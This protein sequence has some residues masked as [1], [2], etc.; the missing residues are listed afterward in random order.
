M[1]PPLLTTTGPPSEGAS[2]GAV[3]GAAAEG[4]AIGA[5]H[6]DA[7]LRY[8]RE[9]GPGS[10][11]ALGK[12]VGIS[13]RSARDHLARLRAEG[14]VEKTGAR[15][16]LT[17]A[18][19]ARTG[20]TATAADM[21]GVLALLPSE[22][23]RAWLRLVRDAVLCRTAHAG[24]G[25]RGWPGFAA[26]GPPGTMKTSLAALAG[27][28][29]GLADHEHVLVVSDRAP[30]D[31]IGRKD[32]RGRWQRAGAIGLPVL[33]LDELDKAAGDRLAIALRLLQG[34]SVI[35]W[36]GETFTMPATVLCTFN[37]GKDPRAVLPPDR[38]RR[39]VMLNTSG[40]ASPDAC[41]AAARTLLRP[42][43]LPVLDAGRL[44]PSAEP[45]ADDVAEL[46]GAELSERML[47]GARALL[48]AEGLA[49]IVPGR[50]VNDSCSEEEAALAIGRDYLVCAE[51]WGG[52][53]ARQ[54]ARWCRDFGLD[55]PG[56]P[57]PADAAEIA[58][59]DTHVDAV[60]LAGRRA[61]ARRSVRAERDA[62]GR[63]DDAEAAYLRG[64][65][66]ELLRQVDRVQTMG[67]LRRLDQTFGRLRALGEQR[68]QAIA[69]RQLAAAPRRSPAARRLVVPDR[70]A[71]LA[72][73]ARVGSREPPV[74]VLERL[75]LVAEDPFL[76]DHAGPNGQRWRATGADVRG[77][78]LFDDARWP[79]VEVRAILTAALAREPAPDRPALSLVRG[80]G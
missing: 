58:A 31:L 72:E 66:A 30:S 21:D 62:L 24:R 74:V 19:A 13:E 70:G 11:P 53:T 3:R 29:F 77:V 48:P 2:E 44:T 9:R 76:G 40:L 78:V 65:F 1:L 20:S 36:E 42:G 54:V 80:F 16:R 68:A 63:G 47:P 67:E 22:P 32:A 10:A 64:A 51:T 61:V 5:A 73:L 43:A 26:F 45:V 75:G 14:L 38:I 18:G 49:L 8:L 7:I 35:S 39:M 12:A 6:R 28:T 23:H 50:A 56:G 79:D 69:G 46:L 41:R 60:D 59:D 15:W 17:P 4:A 27:R 55:G 71:Y 25:E 34:D 57:E 52:T 37:A 33:T